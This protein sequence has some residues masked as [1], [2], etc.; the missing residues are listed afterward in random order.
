MVFIRKGLITKRLKVFE[1][2]ISETICLEVTISKKVWFITYVYRPPYNNKDIFFSELSN[3]LSLATRKYENILIIGDLNTDTLNKKKVNGNYL[4]DLC[5]TFS[6]KNLIT[7]IT[8]VKSTN[9]TSIDVLLTNKSRCFH[10]T[11]SYL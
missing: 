2:D 8:Y 3:I 7:D 1:G 10:H 9:G 4:S 6:L 5:D 11:A